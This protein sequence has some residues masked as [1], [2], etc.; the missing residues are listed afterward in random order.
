[1]S[2][3]YKYYFK[4]WCRQSGKDTDDL[5][6]ELF[7]LWNNPGKQA[8]YVGLDN[9]WVKENIFRKY[10]DGRTHWKNY[11]D[12]F[13]NILPTERRVE[14][15]NKVVDDLAPA[16]LKFMGFY[17]EESLIGSAYDRFVISEASLYRRQ[18][19]QYMEPIWYMKKAQNL[20]FSVN[21]NGTPRG[22]SNNLYDMLCAYTGETE[23]EAFWGEHGDVYAEKLTVEDL[24]NH[25]G[26]RLFPDSLLEKMQETAIR[27]F[28]N[29]NLFRQEYYCDFTTVNSAVI[30]QGIE[31]LRRENRYRGFELNVNEPLF[32]AWDI[33]SKGSFT[34][35][36][37]CIFY[38]F[39]DGAFWIWDWSESQGC[40][41]IEC[42][43]EVARRDYWNYVQY[44]LLPWD[45]DIS[46]SES[47]PFHDV[48][49]NFGHI[50]WTVIPRTTLVANDINEVGKALPRMVIHPR[51]DEFGVDWLMECFDNYEYRRL[52]KL[53]DYGKPLHNRYSHMMDALREAVV[54]LQYVKYTGIR[55]K[56]TAPKGPQFYGRK[57][58][59]KKNAYFR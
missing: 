37:S 25:E 11:P 40:A 41:L 14:M 59:Q 22:I 43:R 18:A 45:A 19:F 34:D 46:P 49:K 33:S 42:V 52:L 24:V 7:Q 55:P 21:L 50:R 58:G 48:Q 6:W 56:E 20:D 27:Q 38:Q 51:K 13:I 23:P 54:G 44:G 30:Y 16:S 10:I 3:K 17:N 5:Q 12:E 39:F 53:E 9:A 26:K 32:M 28:G 2:G 29:L 36:T 15:T 57:K 1:M 4:V 31:V 47:S 35:F 8:V